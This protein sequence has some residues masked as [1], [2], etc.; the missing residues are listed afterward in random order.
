M[1]PALSSLNPNGKREREVKDEVAEEGTGKRVRRL[2]PAYSGY[3]QD[4]KVAAMNSHLFSPK[5]PHARGDRSITPSHN[6]MESSADS[7]SLAASAGIAPETPTGQ[8]KRN[9][10]FLTPAQAGEKAKK[11]P[12]GYAL[13][14]VGGAK[15][16]P[17]VS[18]E[19]SLP[20]KRERKKIDYADYADY[21]T[22]KATPTAPTQKRGK[23]S[24]VDKALL[25]RKKSKLE[26]ELSKLE[27]DL[28]HIHNMTAKTKSMRAM[29]FQCQT[30]IAARPKK[31]KKRAPGSAPVHAGKHR[32]AADYYT[33][34]PHRR[35]STAS[36]SK[37]FEQCK[38]VH[39]Q[40]ME[41]KF[42]WPF[43]QPVDPIAL[44]IPDY[45]TVIKFPMDLGTIMKKLE[46][47]LYSNIDEYADDARLVFQNAQT[48]NAEGSDIFYMS[49][50]LSDQFEKKFIAIRAKLMQQQRQAAAA[51]V[52]ATPIPPPDA[53]VSSTLAEIK[54]AVAS[55][56]S[57][58]KNLRQQA[59]APPTP[60]AP[61]KKAAN[62]KRRT[63][64]GRPSMK[65]MTKEEK[66][67]LSNAIN[68][69][70]PEH[71]GTVVQII[72]ERMP[73][74]AQQTNNDEIEIDIDALDAQTL[75]HLEEFVKSCNAPRPRGGRLA[76]KSGKGKHA[77][78]QVDDV[79]R[80]L[81]AITHTTTAR[82]KMVS[83]NRNIIEDDVHVDVVGGGS[84]D[85]GL[86]SSS[87]S[88]SSSETSSDT[89]DEEPAT[90]ASLAAKPAQPTALT[91]QAK[92]GAEAM[93]SK[94]F[95]EVKE[96]K[97]AKVEAAKPAPPS[98]QGHAPPALDQ[99]KDDVVFGLSKQEAPAS[100]EQAQPEVI[101][102]ATAKKPAMKEVQLSNASDWADIH[103]DED[104]SN[105]VPAGQASNEL[106]SK[107]KNQEMMM[108]QREKEKEEV[109]E[110]L[111][112]ER[113]RKEQERRD[114]E[115]RR[116]QQQQQE[117]AQRRSAEERVLRE[118][119]EARRQAKL[120]REQNLKR[121]QAIEQ[122]SIMASFEAGGMLEGDGDSPLRLPSDFSCSPLRHAPLSP[123]P[124]SPM[125]SSPAPTEGK[126][127]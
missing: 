29:E 59:P 84:R 6:V 72:H 96:V 30:P 8:R 26:S 98:S 97:E 75:R 18:P 124:A 115:A 46:D 125:H 119:E 27:S 92:K 31:T 9:E 25:E 89:E 111:R 101:P 85:N 80:S 23:H 13:V 76:P 70:A 105:G 62:S 20:R 41:H 65:S 42:S 87:S 60:K 37:A 36:I 82:S 19:E 78:P 10:I 99:P 81:E 109:E 55:L 50:V 3:E 104:E 56:Q 112:L 88:S 117:E 67:K 51:P 58:I 121:T 7:I 54:N 48:Y 14:P 57:E 79:Q 11:L 63:P 22:P 4:K 122:T 17:A 106:W 47:D 52:Y 64:A 15:P 102:I 33:P 2:N 114:M 83:R 103:D 90:P 61:P 38:K 95:K 93:E 120:E 40:L 28:E 32:A 43:N 107:M 35:Q 100:N 123:M 45:F 24:S 69:L 16:A 34:Q 74:L 110:K 21:T 66:R 12:K 108:K 113:E 5:I 68:T 73:S 77:R 126:T 44:N 1:D 49:Q 91:G 94:D 86:D 39:R 116:K 53:F 127:Q 118:R 71:L